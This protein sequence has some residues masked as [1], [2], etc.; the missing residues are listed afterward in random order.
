MNMSSPPTVLELAYRRDVL[1]ALE[2]IDAVTLRR[3]SR[4]VKPVAEG[5]RGEPI[6]NAGGLFVWLHEEI[7]ALRRI[8]FDTDS[9]PLR[10]DDVDAADL[11]RPLMTLQLSPTAGY[12][13]A[14][15]TTAVRS[16][17]L[18]SNAGERVPLANARV[19]LAW[20]DDQGP[21]WRDAPTV[22]RTGPRGD[23]AALLRLAPSHLPQFDANGEITVRLFASRDGEAD[24]RFTSPFQ[25]PQGRVT[26]APAFAWD[27]LQ[28]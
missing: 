28:S 23:F 14:A 6:V 2:L 16:V 24:E 10:V 21:T 15:G 12:P 4:G 3:V 17:V 9:L 20:L 5:L 22:S 27:D 26:D 25:I 19:R 13:F 18:E 7:S 11:Q 8:T 1:F